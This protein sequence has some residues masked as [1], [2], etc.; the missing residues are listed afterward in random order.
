M[1]VSIFIKIILIIPFLIAGGI[2]IAAL[3]YLLV[4]MMIAGSIFSILYVI[5]IDMSNN[6]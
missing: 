5:T 4:P 3:S 6:N 2:A 1:P